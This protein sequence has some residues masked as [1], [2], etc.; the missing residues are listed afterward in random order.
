MFDFLSF[1]SDYDSDPRRSTPAMV[2]APCPYQSSRACGVQ[3]D[4]ARG[5]PHPDPTDPNSDFPDP[6]LGEASSVI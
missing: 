6:D 4:R 2:S 1:Q 5:D 3:L